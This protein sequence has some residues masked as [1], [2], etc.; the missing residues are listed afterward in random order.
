MVVSASTQE[1]LEWVLVTSIP[2]RRLNSSDVPIEFASACLVDY[3]GRRFLLSV[4]HAVDMGSK[5]WIVDL[6]YESGKGTAFYRPYS[7]NY[8]AEMIR[9]S[10]SI[11]GI[12]FCYTEVT[13]D[14][15]S[16]Y[17]HMTPRGILDERVRHVFQIDLT[18]LPDSNQIFAFSG[19]VKPEMHSAQTFAAEMNVYPG[20]R[21]LRT[22]SEFHI[23]KLPVEHP[24]HEH[25]RGCSGAPIVDM[26]QSVV[27]LVC[28]GDESTNTIRGVSLARYKFAFDFICNRRDDA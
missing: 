27:A 17:Q 15:T 26:N 21:Y 19:Q 22:E 16:T 7:F 5:D 20:L 25:F 12:D 10:G 9:G 8:V 13:S 6:G 4:Q 11:R 28:D 24:G 2:L 23:F 3:R 18:A 14:L 1:W